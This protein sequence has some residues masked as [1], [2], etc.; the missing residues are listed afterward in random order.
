[1]F[2]VFFSFIHINEI[3]HGL[4]LLALILLLCKTPHIHL[5]LLHWWLLHWRLVHWW[6]LH[7]RLVCGLLRLWL[8]YWSLIHRWSTHT[9]HTLRIL[10]WWLSLG[11]A[12]RLRSTRSILKILKLSHQ[13][14]HVR[15]SRSLILNII[16]YLCFFYLFWF[17]NFTLPIIAW[18]IWI[19]TWRLLSCLEGFH[20][21]TGFEDAVLALL[22]PFSFLK[23]ISKH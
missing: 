5:W 10:H 16:W 14:I 2:N 9:H 11:W 12:L 19:S 1:M 4:Y 21:A 3:L 23:S 8:V 20:D 6:L 17:R 18:I 7:W 15:H 22:F 13:V